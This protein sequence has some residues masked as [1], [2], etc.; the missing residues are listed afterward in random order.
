MNNL[1]AV[2]QS[3]WQGV[4]ASAGIGVWGPSPPFVLGGLSCALQDV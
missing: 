3:P 2:P 1:T 4:S